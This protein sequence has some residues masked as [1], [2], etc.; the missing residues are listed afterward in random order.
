MLEPPSARGG[1]TCSFGGML[2][3]G[4]AVAIVVMA[5]EWAQAVST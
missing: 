3:H 1:V 5:W 2:K 4:E